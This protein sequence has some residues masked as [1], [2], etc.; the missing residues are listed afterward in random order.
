MTRPSVACAVLHADS[1]GNSIPCPGYPHALVTRCPE[2]ETDRC[3][4]QWA[5]MDSSDTDSWACINGHSWSEG[6]V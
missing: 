5:A 3:W 4:L 1:D 2:C 6:V